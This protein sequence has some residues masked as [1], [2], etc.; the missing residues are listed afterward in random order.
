MADGP[1]DHAGACAEC[2]GQESRLCRQR[3]ENRRRGGPPHQGGAAGLRDAESGAGLR[4]AREV[5]RHQVRSRYDALLHRGRL[6]RR[7]PADRDHDREPPT[8]DRDPARSGRAPFHRRA[9]A[10]EDPAV[11]E[12]GHPARS[13]IAAVRRTRGRVARR[14]SLAESLGGRLRRRDG[15]SGVVRHREHRRAPAR[16]ARSSIRTRP[17]SA[18]PRRSSSTTRVILQRPFTASS[19]RSCSTRSR[20]I[21]QRRDD[22]WP[23]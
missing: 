18:I 8:S 5:R 1:P 21:R 19:G 11:F 2:V 3:R 20:R 16:D 7:R 15:A 10:H 14:R 4:R 13:R 22:G 12:D 23:D 9:A 6:E 17:P